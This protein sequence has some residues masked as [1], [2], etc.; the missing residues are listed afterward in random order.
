VTDG[1]SISTLI[2]PEFGI[3]GAPIRFDGQQVSYSC[4]KRLCST[5][6]SKVKLLSANLPLSDSGDVISLYKKR[7]FPFAVDEKLVLIKR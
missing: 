6:L 2:A 1:G 7:Y 3:M 5:D 4:G